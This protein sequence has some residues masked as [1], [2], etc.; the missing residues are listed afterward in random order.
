MTVMGDNDHI[1]C[2][3]GNT[4][5]INIVYVLINIVYILIRQ[6]SNIMP[7]IC[8]EV[9]ERLDLVTWVTDGL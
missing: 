9:Y 1:C 4:M 8:K 5:V 6:E 2:S 7:S 3:F